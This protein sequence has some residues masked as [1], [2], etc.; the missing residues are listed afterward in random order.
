MAIK[1]C[2]AAF[3]GYVD[4]QV[5]MVTVGALL[6]ESDPII[7]GREALFEDVDTYVETRRSDAAA[8]RLQSPVERATAE[9]G[10]KRT[11]S[12]PRNRGRAGEENGS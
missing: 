11:V 10:E 9:P 3:S 7:K 6:D 5:R 4:G 1:R 8:T 2:K 12:R